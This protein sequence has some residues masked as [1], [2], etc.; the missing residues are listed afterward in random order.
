MAAFEERFG[1]GPEVE[2]LKILGL[3]ER[4]AEDAAVK[5]LRTQP[6][7]YGL[8]QHLSR[9]TELNGRKLIEKLRDL[10]LIANKSTH[11]PKSLDCHPLIREHF[12]EMLKK[13]NIKAWRAGHNRLYKFYKSHAKDFPNTIEEMTPLFSAVAHGCAAGRHQKAMDEVYWKRIC[14]GM[15]SSAQ[16]NSAHS[17]LISPVFPISLRRPGIHLLSALLRRLRRSVLGCGGF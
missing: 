14:R 11:N 5:A 8:T 2:L 7:I 13:D 12:G 3:F 17:A 4:P 9:I 16:S 15:N 1:D 6:F 10:K